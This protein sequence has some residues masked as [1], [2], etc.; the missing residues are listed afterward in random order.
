M[1]HT[2]KKYSNG[3]SRGGTP[4]QAT[5]T[6]RKEG[7]N[8]KDYGRVAIGFHGGDVSYERWVAAG[9]KGY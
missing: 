6:S 2:K 5:N 7:R 3:Q 8:P 9:R 4:G 1:A